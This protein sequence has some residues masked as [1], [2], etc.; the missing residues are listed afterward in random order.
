MQPCLRLEYQGV[1]ELDGLRLIAGGVR[2][3]RRRRA[4]GGFVVA[5]R[6]RGVARQRGGLGGF[7]GAQGAPVVGVGK[8]GHTWHSENLWWTARVYLTAAR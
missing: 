6:R 4:R 5:G 7:L 3:L 2:S 1:A 8:L